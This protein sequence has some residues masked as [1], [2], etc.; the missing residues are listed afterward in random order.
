MICVLAT[1]ETASG[2]RDELLAVIRWVVPLVRA[3]SGC[4]EYTP[5][6]DTVNDMTKVRPDVVTMVEKW[7]SVAA[8]K[9][10]LATPHMVEFVKRAEPLGLKMGLQIVEPS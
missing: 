6:V 3:E 8:L 5:M 10:H 1:L 9:A 4:L 7:E 2:K